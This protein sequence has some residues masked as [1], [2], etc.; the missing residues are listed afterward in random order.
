MTTSTPES[1]N[2]PARQPAVVTLLDAAAARKGHDIG[3]LCKTL[4]FT[5][6]YYKQLATGIRPVS[7]VSLGLAKAMA[8]YVGMSL[9]DMYKVLHS[10]GGGPQP[11][12]L[13]GEK[14]NFH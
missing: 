6:G 4:G 13:T 12:H 3:T 7:T 9:D 1:S 5:E 14:R 8:D 11:P 2:A 10:E